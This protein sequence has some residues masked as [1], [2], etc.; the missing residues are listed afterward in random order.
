MPGRLRKYAR[1][2]G[3]VQ[4]QSAA[5]A[6]ATDI[7][8]CLVSIILSDGSRRISD[9]EA[10]KAKKR[11]W[12][13]KGIYR[14]HIL[15]SQSQNLSRDDLAPGDLVSDRMV[16]GDTE[17]VHTI[18]LNERKTRESRLWK[19]DCSRK[20]LLKFVMRTEQRCS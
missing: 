6:N 12:A 17:C 18:L 16:N 20:Y 3:G 14:W 5:G 4:F 19:A 2:L 8:L 9:A 10:C 1:K 13:R 11:T 7:G 15:A